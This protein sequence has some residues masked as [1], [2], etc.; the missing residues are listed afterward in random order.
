MHG[1]DACARQHRIG[2]FN[3]HRHVDADAVAFFN[4]AFFHGVGESAHFGMQ[5]LVGDGLVV[6]RLV[7]FPDNRRLVAACFQVAVDAVGRR[8]ERA[9]FVPFDRDV[10][11]HEV[12]VFN[13][14]VGLNPVEPLALFAPKA[15]VVFDRSFV[16]LLVFRFIR[17]GG[18]GEFGWNRMDVNFAHNDVSPYAWVIGTPNAALS[19][20]YH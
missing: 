3:D 12:D 20:R 11:H 4:A 1:T 6:G 19:P 10:G 13:F 5:L 16:H 14:G 9:V 15:L 8:V 17:V 7:A 18:F 2:G